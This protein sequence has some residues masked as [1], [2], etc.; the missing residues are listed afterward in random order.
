M[1]VGA[2]VDAGG[3]ALV[4]MALIAGGEHEAAV[5]IGAFDEVAFPHLQPDARMAE[6][7]PTPS[8]AIRLERTTITSGG[9]ASV[10]S[11]A[12]AGAGS[13]LRRASGLRAMLAPLLQ[14]CDAT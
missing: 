9:E 12:R 6:R 3:Q 4:L 13:G 2:F 7:A 8:Q 10:V 1:S 5:A 14:C 11:D